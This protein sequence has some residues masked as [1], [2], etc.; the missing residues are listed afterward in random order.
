MSV[1][2]CGSYMNTQNNQ[3]NKSVVR[4]DGEYVVLAYN[5]GSEE[6]SEYEWQSLPQSAKWVAYAYESAPYEGSGYALVAFE[7]GLFSLEDLGHCSCY[8]PTESLSPQGHFTREEVE[9]KLGKDFNG[10]E[11]VNGDWG[12]GLMQ[13]MWE[14]AKVALSDN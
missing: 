13:Q 12:Y 4:K 3:V 8:G 11:I 6:L 2:V 5:G 10:N 1:E 14:A 7:D 9:Q